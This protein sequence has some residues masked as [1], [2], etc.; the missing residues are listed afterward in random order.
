MYILLCLL[1]FGSSPDPGFS[2]NRIFVDYKPVNYFESDSL[3]RINASGKEL[4]LEF[5][6]AGDDSLTYRY[7]LEGY[8][9]DW[10][11][12]FYP[13]ARYTHLPAGNYVFHIRAL[14]N[15]VETAAYSMNIRV[16]KSVS[17]SWWFLPLII[18]W[19]VLLVGGGFYLFFLNNFRQK[20]KVQNL[21]NRISADLHDEIGST[22]S[23]IAISA[24]VVTQKLGDISPEVSGLLSQIEA[25]SRD[26]V[27]QVRETVWMLNPVNDTFEALIEK[28]RSFA[29]QILSAKEITIDFTTTIPENRMP[30]ITPDQRKDFFLIAKEAIHNIARHSGATNAIIKTH[31]TETEIVLEI[32]DNGNGLDFL[33]T[34]EGNGLRNMKRR[35]EKSLFEF[36]I[37]A[38]DSGGTRVRLKVPLL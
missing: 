6:V 9:M 16:D 28:I 21:R 20:M 36:E 2:L 35:A 15:S 24:H 23:S 1:L 10:V 26:I 7:Q 38:P 11:S 22:L 27:Y 32:S 31:R 34:H 4:R 5:K 8:E 19:V 30:P 13:V 18:F 12:T 17:E 29:V 14:K 3:L 25:D 33:T 37:S